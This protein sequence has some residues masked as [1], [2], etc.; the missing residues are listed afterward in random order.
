MFIA[1]L[2]A[3]LFGLIPGLITYRA[4]R[5]KTRAGILS[6]I[7][8][9][10]GALAGAAIVSLFRSDVLFGLYAIG[11]TIGF[12]GYFALDLAFHGKQG[13]ASWRTIVLPSADMPASP[14]P[15]TRPPGA[16]SSDLTA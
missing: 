12:F 1:G 15:V 4:L 6:E 2:G 7:L 5:L 10:F 11:L 14:P 8:A 9:V 16:D 3:L 13:T